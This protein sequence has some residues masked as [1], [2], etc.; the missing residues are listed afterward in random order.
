MYVLGG[1]FLDNIIIDKVRAL[2]GPQNMKLNEP[3]KLHTSIKTGGPVDLLLLPDTNRKME[4]L[5][6]L[7]NNLKIPVFVMGKGTNLLVSDKGIRGVVIKT[8]EGLSDIEV[9]GEFMKVSA[10]VLMSKAAKAALLN[11][12]SGM[13][14]A[15]GIPGTIGGAISMNAGAYGGEMQDIVVES[16]ILDEDFKLRVISAKEHGFMYRKSIF[17]SNKNVVLSTKLKL[18]TGNKKDIKALMNDLNS[19]RKV[20]QPLEYPSA[21]SVFKRPEGNF[22]PPLIEKCELKGYRVGGACISEKHC[23][24]IIN[25]NNA[26]SLDVLKLIR[27]IQQKVLNV[28]NIKLEP[29][30]RIIGEWD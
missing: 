5:L 19:R 27:H 16:T 3:M 29:E 11:N 25:D 15:S 24:F 12:L 18:S 13:E 20:K 23:G 14:F 17:Q 7:L 4:E 9:D 28:F 8:Y 30:I 1:E 2:I 10:G 26:T 22:V 6:F 21:G